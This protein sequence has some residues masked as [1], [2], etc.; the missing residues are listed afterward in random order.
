MKGV[1]PGTL[2][3]LQKAHVSGS[4]SM[5]QGIRHTEI[6]FQGSGWVGI[7]GFGPVVVLSGE[8]CVCDALESVGSCVRVLVVV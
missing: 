7:A 3:T 2:T 1:G 6:L 8:K 5:A 4:R